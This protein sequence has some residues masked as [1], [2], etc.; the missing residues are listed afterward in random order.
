MPEDFPT[1]WQDGQWESQT[2]L[3][4]LLFT[5]ITELELDGLDPGALYLLTASGGQ[6][7]DP[8]LMFAL[9]EGPV[10]VQGDWHA[11]VSGQRILDGSVEV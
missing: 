3:G 5:G 1:L 9:S 2:T 11:I 4:Q 10:L 7:F 6:D 8:D